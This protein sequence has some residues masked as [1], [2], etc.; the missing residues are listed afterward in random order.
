MEEADNP[1]REGR[2]YSPRDLFVRYSKAIVRVQVTL[3]KGDRS[4]GTAFHVGGGA[5]V[6]AR[7]VVENCSDVRLFEGDTWFEEPGYCVQDIRYP[8]GKADLALLISPLF[9]NVFGDHGASA[10]EGSK[11][12]RYIPIGH[13]Y[14]DWIEDSFVLTSGLIAGYPEVPCTKR[15]Y[16]IAVSAEVNADVDRYD[17]ENVHFIVSS[18]A[19]GGFSGAPFISE[20]D[21]VLGVV[22][23]ALQ[24]DGSWESPYMAVVSV[25]PLINLIAQHSELTKSRLFHPLIF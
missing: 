10:S 8:D 13:C 25:E 4:N 14:D 18:S 19:R 24:K 2:V 5:F 9:A 1:W 12:P 16:M 20:F 23:N 22:T 6:T 17:A 11:D 15:P 21:F 7:H 3:P